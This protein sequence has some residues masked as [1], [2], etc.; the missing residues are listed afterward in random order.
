MPYNC[1]TLIV[2]GT[3]SLQLLAGFYLFLTSQRRR[4]GT[5]Q[6][7]MARDSAWLLRVS[8][9]QLDRTRAESSRARRC[10][11]S[12]SARQLCFCCQF[13]SVNIPTWGEKNTV[14]HTFPFITRRARLCL[15]ASVAR[16]PQRTS[17]TF[18]RVTFLF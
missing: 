8:R 13:Y 7:L 6:V 12:S 9:E 1:Y 4:V 15:G 14:G 2:A 3:R 5:L 18:V 16:G 11:T 17:T 10:G